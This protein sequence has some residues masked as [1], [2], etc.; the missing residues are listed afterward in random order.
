[1]YPHSFKEEFSSGF[2][3][4]ILLA[5]RHNGHLREFVDDHEN[6]VISMLSRRKARHVIH[7]DGFPR[8][9][10][11]RQ[12]SIEALLLDGRFGNGVG[13]AGSDVLPDIL[14]K[15]WP[16]EILLQYCHCFLDPKCQRPDYSVLPKSSWH[17]RL[18][19]HK[20]V[21]GN[22]VVHPGG[23]NLELGYPPRLYY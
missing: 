10:R 8:S 15:V 14:S 11:G 20:G 16:I 3:C 13:S 12:W 7:G 23:E 17:A 5:G 19:E 1:V 18:K 2:C 21:P 9:T 4:D 22:I 6:T